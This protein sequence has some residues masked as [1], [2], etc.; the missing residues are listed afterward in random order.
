MR[1]QNEL[2]MAK[3]NSMDLSPQQIM[4]SLEEKAQVSFAMHRWDSFLKETPRNVKKKTT[5]EQNCLFRQVLQFMV[6]E[7][8]PKEIA[9]KKM[10][11]QVYEDVINERNI[12]NQYLTSLQNQVDKW[13]NIIHNLMQFDR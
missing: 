4:N 2:K 8:L 12:N 1:L 6:E 7:K 3:T 11:L 13:T 10:E 5:N 9:T